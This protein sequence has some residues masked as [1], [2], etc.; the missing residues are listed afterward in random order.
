MLGPGREN[1]FLAL[2]R[3]RTR[4]ALEEEHGHGHVVAKGAASQA[5]G[6]A[7]KQRQNREQ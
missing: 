7:W 3:G 6:T 2:W 1:G 5:E 4:A